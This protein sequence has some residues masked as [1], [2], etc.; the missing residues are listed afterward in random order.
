M[1]PLDAPSAP[2]DAPGIAAAP[3]E[4]EDT[5]AYELPS[6]GTLLHTPFDAVQRRMGGQ[7]AEWEGWDWISDFGDPIAEHHAVRETVGIWDESPLQKWLFKGPDALAAADYCFTS[8][9]AGAGGRPGALRRVLRRARQDARR[10]HRLQHG[11]QRRGHPRRH[12]ALDRRRPLPPRDRRPG[13][14]RR[15]R[16]AHRRDAAP[17]A[18]GAEVARAAR[19]ADGRR[20]RLAALLPLPRGRHDRRRA[21]LPR[22]AHGLLGRARLRDLHVA[23]ERRAPLERAARRRASRSASAPTA[24]PRSSRCASSRA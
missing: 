13:A 6:T 20:H 19:V 4:D 16:R 11:R 3:P 18:A 12:G 10:R 23:R 14:R 7:F 22:L 8:D 21:R 2:L 15:G 17:P 1:A 5:G 24:S 9:M